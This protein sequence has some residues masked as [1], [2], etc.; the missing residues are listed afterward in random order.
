MRRGLPR[1][2]PTGAHDWS[3]ALTLEAQ[4]LL[5]FGAFTSKHVGTIGL[6]NPREGHAKLAI[7]ITDKVLRTRAIGGCLPQLLRGP[8]VGGRADHTDMDHSARV[9]E[10]DEEDEQQVEE[11]ISDR[12]KIAGP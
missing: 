5:V 4:K 8:S 7:V 11:E 9:Q 6:G 10:G 1:Y 3:Q 12:K 2:V